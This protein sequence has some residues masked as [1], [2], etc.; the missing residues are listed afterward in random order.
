MTDFFYQLPNHTKCIY[1]CDNDL[2]NVPINGDKPPTY[3]A[4]PVGVWPSPM[5]TTLETVD[6]VEERYYRI[7][8]GSSIVLEYYPEDAYV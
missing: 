8:S 1:G 2:A 5:V 6:L 7:S 3:E 4:I